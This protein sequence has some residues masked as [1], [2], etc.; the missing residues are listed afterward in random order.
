MTAT[1]SIR[2]Y[3]HGFIFL[4]T[5]LSRENPSAESFKEKSVSETNQSV[6]V[7]PYRIRARYQLSV[8][9]ISICGALLGPDRVGG[10]DPG[11]CAEVAVIPRR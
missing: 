5:D 10:I 8:A 7:I 11:V 4:S 2:N 3:G 6:A 1:D 9:V